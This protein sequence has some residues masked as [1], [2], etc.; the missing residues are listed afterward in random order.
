MNARLKPRAPSRV[1][2]SAGLEPSG[3]LSFA[4]VASHGCEWRTR[5]AASVLALAMLASP[6]HAQPSASF[7]DL[8]PDLVSRIASELTAGASI[9][10]SCAN[11]QERVRAEAARLLAARGFRVVDSGD[12]TNVGCSCEANLR[13]RVCAASIVR[14]DTRRV[15]MATR[16]LAEG[17]NAARDAVVAMEL[18]PIYTQQG[19]M[20]DVAEANNQLLVLSP[21]SVSLVGDTG[22]GNVTGRA[23][24]SRPI[25]TLRVWPRDVRGTLRVAGAGFEAFLPGVVCRGTVTPFTLACADE[26]EPWPIG[27]DNSGLTPSRNTFATPEGVTFYEAAP[28]GG[29]RWL[30]VGEQGT[31]TFLDARRRVDARAESADHAAGF[32]DSC[33]GDTSYVVT[34]S[35]GPQANGDTLRLARATDER[36]AALPSTLVLPGALTALWTAP[37][38]RVATAVV[39]D[40]NAGRYEAFHLTL[41]CAR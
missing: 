32:S 25:K 40:V 39:H 22:G 18:R 2:R 37:G 33:G 27:L 19:P 28:L 30:V 34:A 1:C 13:E 8:T 5:S 10:L 17:G 31:L 14:G 38:A 21:D 24:A 20:L 16:A 7:I 4:S 3:L 26:S 15:V 41:S 35:G 9:R 11:D 29:G 12:V 23:I 6:A 36:L